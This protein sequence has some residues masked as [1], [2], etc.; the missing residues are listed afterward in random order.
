MLSLNLP[1]EMEDHIIQSAKEANISYNEFIQR[2][3]ESFLHDQ[4][5]K[6][7][8]KDLELLKQGKLK[9]LSSEEV[10]GNVRKRLKNG[11]HI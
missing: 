3:I 8:K 5:I 2:A 4:R 9:L 7:Y 11:N 6:N 10:F 1:L